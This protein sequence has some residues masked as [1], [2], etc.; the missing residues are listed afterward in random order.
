MRS[1]TVALVAVTFLFAG[2]ASANYT[3]DLIWADT[4]SATLT[5]TAL[6]DPGAPFTRAGVQF[7]VDRHLEEGLILA[8]PATRPQEYMLPTRGV[9]SLDP[10]KF[11]NVPEGVP[12]DEP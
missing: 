8:V 6:G 11:V 3:I 1:I 10:A 5:V 12:P 7:T 9:A 2:N 4:G